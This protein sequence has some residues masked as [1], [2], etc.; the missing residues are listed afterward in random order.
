MTWVSGTVS[1]LVKQIWID[2]KLSKQFNKYLRD[3]PEEQ[4]KYIFH[5]DNFG[6]ITITPPFK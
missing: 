6:K 1:N 3:T 2:E 4:L 5:R